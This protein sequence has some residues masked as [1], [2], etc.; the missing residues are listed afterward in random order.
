VS[1]QTGWTEDAVQPPHLLLRTALGTLRPE[2][3]IPAVANGREVLVFAGA[4]DESLPVRFVDLDSGAPLPDRSLLHSPLLAG[5]GRGAGRTLLATV[6]ARGTVAVRAAETGEPTGP[7]IPGPAS[8]RAVVTG[9]V[10][11]REVVAVSGPD[12]T[13]VWDVAGGAEIAAPGFGGHALVAYEGRLLAVSGGVHTWQLRDVLTGEACGAPFPAR[14]TIVTAVV[15]RGRVLVVAPGAPGPAWDVTA[16]AEVALPEL[17]LADGSGRATLRRVA[18]TE[19]DQGLAA[20]VTWAVRD[21]GDRVELW[22]PG[23]GGPRRSVL[24]DAAAAAVLHQDGQLLTAVAGRSG[25]L[26]VTGI[27]SP[28]YGGPV[29]SFGGWAR[30]SGRMLAVLSGDP[31][32]LYDVEAGRPFA[33]VALPDFA[34]E[35]PV[36]VVLDAGGFR[37]RDT[38]RDRELLRRDGQHD[39]GT[40]AVTATGYRE[41]DD[42]ALLATGGADGSVRLWNVSARAPAGGPWHGHPG[43]VTAVALARRRGRD[44]VL[45]AD[46]SGTVRMWVVGGP[47]RQAGHTDQVTVVTGG[48]RA[49]HPVVASGGEDGTIRFW[50][51]VTGAGVG[52]PI[53]CGPV[54]GLAFAGNVLVANGAGVVR[55]W[56]PATCEPIGEPLSR[57][58]SGRLAAAELDGRHLVAAVTDDRLRVWDAATGEPYGTMP[59]PGPAALQDLAVHD[60]RLLALTVS[61]PDRALFPEAACMNG[62]Q[63]TIWDVPAAAPHLPPMLTSDDGGLG[64]FGRV[65]GRLMAA[66]G[67]DARKNE[68][69]GVWPE[70]AGD[71]YLRD[72]TTGELGVDYRPEAGFNQQLCITRVGER[73][74]VLVAAESAVVTWDA[75]TGRQAAPPVPSETGSLTCVTATEAAGRTYAAAGDWAGTVR[76]WEITPRS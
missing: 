69:E 11:G 42:K 47:V 24:A 8:P 2:S 23:A 61:T 25:A 21:D 39:A 65:G 14:G 64:G 49:G 33:R 5:L 12:E 10:G 76:I 72:L 43:P 4:D 57:S 70:E 28:Y 50:D 18:L 19:L 53:R 13:R 29:R 34:P 32:L 59:L 56:N 51:P 26:S 67:V 35:N 31:A 37:V 27:R 54:A 63:I 15:H 45:S 58:G 46:A 41:T 62:R 74:V 3:I 40:V 7:A 22:L 75:A 6:T 68:E 1:E 36:E 44:V 60:G 16:G 17:W 52:E 30:R 20:V 55:R 66:H 9:V 48:V 73:D 38:V 71:I